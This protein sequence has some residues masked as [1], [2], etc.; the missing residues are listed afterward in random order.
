MVKNGIRILIVLGLFMMA[1]ASGAQEVLVKASVDKQKI[2][3][4]EPL[5][6]KLEVRA[7]DKGDV[8]SFNLDT[9][10]HFEFLKKDSV[11]EE[12]AGGAK[13]IA[14]YY[15]LTS[16][17]SGRW[18]IP[19]VA[20][21]RGI[22]TE[23]I[24]VEVVFSSP[25]DPSQPYHDIQDLRT[26]P[27]RLSKDFERWWY[28]MALLL[29]MLSVAV[30]WMTEDRKPGKEIALA[31]GAYARARHEL[32]VL[33]TSGLTETR[34]YAK[35]V[36]IF[37]TYLSERVGVNS[38]QQTSGSLAGKVNPFFTDPVFYKKVTDI[39]SLCDLVKFAQYEPAAAETKAAYK[40]IDQA[41]DHI[42]AAAKQQSQKMD[43]APG[44][45]ENAPGTVKQ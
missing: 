12:E 39:L 9:I 26:V 29:L 45:K 16:F 17:D 13:I 43:P 23:A 14:H 24:Y 33:K 10:P 15:R 37:R 2:L 5:L 31:R 27:F 22:K 44:L 30:Y 6:L 7:P 36:E 28:L 20:L 21:T 38:M 1:L 35:L 3:I 18:V 19:P 40:I 42:E 34:F 4:G 8:P 25:F 32:T 41:V 11:A